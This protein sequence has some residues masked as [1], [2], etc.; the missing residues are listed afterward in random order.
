MKP[1]VVVSGWC[2][3]VRCKTT[4]P[5]HTSWSQIQTTFPKAHCVLW[6]WWLITAMTAN[7]CFLSQHSDYLK[8]PN[9]QRLCEVFCLAHESATW[10][11]HL[12]HILIVCYCLVQVSLLLSMLSCFVC[13]F[14]VAVCFED[15]FPGC[16]NNC[17][18]AV[19]STSSLQ[20]GKYHVILELVS[21]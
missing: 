7:T 5:S 19:T 6:T 9:S 17:Y 12:F 2:Q 20:H 15:V 18:S 11:S 16:V 3:A 13:D 4:I 1:L 21:R 10:P 14:C 8:T